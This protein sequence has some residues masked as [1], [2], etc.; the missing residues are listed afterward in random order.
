MKLLIVDD[1]ALM[2]RSLR[3]CFENEADIEVHTAR[4]GK[5]ALDQIR[6]I[7]PDVV[8]L[9]INMPVMDGLTC[10]SHIMT[11]AP[12]PVVMV[13]SLTEKGATITFEALEIGAVDYVAKPGGTV[14]LNLKSVFPDIVAKVRAAARARHRVARPLR[15]RLR[16]DRARIAEKAIRS[17]RVVG[18]SQTAADLV[19]VG[20][21]TGGPR[22]LESILE[23]L[24]ADYPVPILIAQHMPG[25][26]TGVFA[27]RLNGACA[28]AVGEV[29]SPTPLLPGTAYVARGDADVVVSLRGGRPTAVSVPCDPAH[30]WHPSVDRMVASAAQALPAERLIA[31]QLTGMGDDGV[32]AICGLR[33]SGGRTIAESADTAVIYGMPKELIEQGGADKVL[34]SHAIAEQ[35]CRWATAP[36]RR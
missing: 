30:T 15:E 28:I 26:F 9:D 11:E 21:S 14:S 1:S 20:V 4:D 3:E 29:A 12:R 25:R 7:E 6:A 23:A 31:V 36:A 22:T 34:P 17:V 5:D 19:L 33:A 10:L 18:S 13:S 2:R 32:R 24:P 27:E 35:L 8:T 16:A